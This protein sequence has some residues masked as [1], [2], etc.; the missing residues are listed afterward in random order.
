[1]LLLAGSFCVMCALRGPLEKKLFFIGKGDSCSVYHSVQY[2]ST[3][4]NLPPYI[5]LYAAAGPRSVTTNV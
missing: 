3:F 4:D 1:M 5:V 2:L